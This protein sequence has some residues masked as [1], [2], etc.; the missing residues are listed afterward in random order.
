LSNFVKN[1][2]RLEPPLSRVGTSSNA[3][4]KRNFWLAK[5]LTSRH[6]CVLRVTFCMSNTLRKLMIRAQ[7]LVFW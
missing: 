4:V 7:D 3:S 1:V 5:F 2:I 6:V